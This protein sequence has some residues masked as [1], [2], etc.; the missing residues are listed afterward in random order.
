M[1]PIKRG[2]K[3][4]VG[5]DMDGYISKFDVYQGRNAMPKDY[6]FPASF[7]LEEPV[8]AHFTSDQLQ[9]SH[10]VY[11][12]NYFSSVPLME[13]LKTRNVFAC[14]TIRSNRKYLPNKL[15]TNKVMNRGDFDYRVS[16][17]KIVY[18]KWMDNNP[19]HIISNFHN[20]EQ[21]LILRRQRDGF[22][23]ELSCPT[24]VKDYN[25]Y[26][27]GVDK[28][29]MLWSIYGVGRRSRK[30]KDRIFFG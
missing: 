6:S 12:D 14:A 7:S 26:M 4:W 24:A 18:F 2:Y 27:E 11:F 19:V 23:L 22:R 17:Q 29:D 9:K 8:V 25:S 28:A 10:P 13:Y 1:K 16:A 5:A 3:L 20:T 15:T 21:T 30:C